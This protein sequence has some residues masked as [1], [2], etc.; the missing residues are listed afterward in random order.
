MSLV[1]RLLQRMQ[2]DWW[3]TERDTV[4][5]LE[6]AGQVIKLRIDLCAHHMPIKQCGDSSA[7]GVTGDEQTAIRTCRVFLKQNLQT[8][9]HGLDHFLCHVKEASVA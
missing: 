4:H 8:L 1:I 5:A 7:S 3:R 2:T 6:E 9:C